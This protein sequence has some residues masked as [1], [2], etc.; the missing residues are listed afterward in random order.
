VMTRPTRAACSHACKATI[1]ELQRL[2]VHLAWSR[3]VEL[4]GS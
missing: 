3:L 1:F 4:A 2:Q